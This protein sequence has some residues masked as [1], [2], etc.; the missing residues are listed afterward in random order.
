MTLHLTNY[1]NAERQSTVAA[2]SDTLRRLL[3]SAFQIVLWLVILCLSRTER[4]SKVW[5]LR[6]ALAK[7][8]GLHQ[9]TRP[10]DLNFEFISTVNLSQESTKALYLHFATPE[11]ILHICIYKH[12]CSIT[13]SQGQFHS[14]CGQ[15]TQKG[16][17]SHQF[18][19]QGHYR[20]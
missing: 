20:Q 17:Q 1:N 15:H 18:M 19:I 11:K 2:S 3:F 4:M 9:K 12:A 16:I 5:F 7:S 13:R 14:P 8:K 6:I 10:K